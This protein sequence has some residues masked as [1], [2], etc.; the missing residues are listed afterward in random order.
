MPHWLYA[1]RMNLTSFHNECGHWYKTLVFRGEIEIISKLEEK[2][3]SIKIL[4][5]HLEED[6]E[7]IDKKSIPPFLYIRIW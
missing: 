4:L 7:I 1:E 2:K 6:K 5:N 3:K